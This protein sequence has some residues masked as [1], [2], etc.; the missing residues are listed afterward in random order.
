MNPFLDCDT[1]INIKGRRFSIETGYMEPINEIIQFKIF[2]DS[3]GGVLTLFT[4]KSLS[5]CDK[6]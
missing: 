1:T 4:L 6:N 2:W 5:R 3:G